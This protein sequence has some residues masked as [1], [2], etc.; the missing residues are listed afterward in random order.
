MRRTSLIFAPILGVLA[1]F[2]TGARDDPEAQVR[3]AVARWR[4]AMLNADIDAVMATISADYRGGDGSDEVQVRRFLDNAFEGGHLA[5]L[6]IDVDQAEVRVE[7]EKAWVFPVRLTLPGEERPL[8]L[9]LHLIEEYGAWRIVSFAGAGDGRGLDAVPDEAEDALPEDVTLQ[10]R[11]PEGRFVR[12]PG[13]SPR[14]QVG[15]R[16]VP[17]RSSF[18]MEIASPVESDAVLADSVS[19]VLETAGGEAVEVLRAGRQFASGYF[20]HLADHP[21][22]S[23]RSLLVFVDSTGELEPDTTYSI[24]VEAR[25]RRG[26]TLGE[27]EGVWSF[28]TEQAPDRHRLD[29]TLDL[30]AE[31]DVYW[32]GAFFNGFAKPAFATSTRQNGRVPHY[33]LMAEAR[34]AY[35][36]AWNLLRDAYLTGFEHQPNV[37]KAYPNLVREKETRRIT[38]IERRERE[39]RLH[40]EDFWGHQ[41]YGIPSG[42]PLSGDY[43]VGDEILI[44]D[45]HQSARATVIA[46]D[47]LARS[48]LVTEF[49]EPAQPWQLEYSQPPPTEENPHSPGLFP[50][51]GTYLRKFDPPG[52]ARYYWGRVHHEWDLLVKRYGFRVIPRFADAPGDLSIDGRNG[53]TAKC[54]VQLHEVTREITGHLIARYGD[55]TLDWPWVVFN[56]PDLTSVYWRTGDWEELQRFYD[57]SSDA[58]LRAFED[59]GYDSSKVQVGGLELGAI[60]GLRMRLEA[61][62]T[63]VSPTASGPGALELNAAYADPRLDGR[64]SRRVEALCEANGGRGAPFDFLS[65]HTYNYSEL[66]AAKLIRAKEVAL[67]IDPE[68]FE[69]LAI[70]NHETVPRWQPIN[71]PGAAEM[72]LG[73]GYF[74]TWAAN[75]VGRLL[76]QAAA[77]P[78]YAYGGEAPL[79]GWPAIRQNWSTLNDVVRRIEVNDRWEVIPSPIFHFVNL[80]STLGDDYYVL[81]PREI[82]GHLV[83]GFAGTTED[84]VRVLLYSHHEQD[85]QSRSDHEFEVLLELLGIEGDEVEVEQ[86]RIDRDHNSYYPLA[87][88]LRDQLA[89]AP[90]RGHTEEEFQAVADRAALKV[91][92]RSTHPVTDAGSATLTARL[93]GN[94]VNFLFVRP[95]R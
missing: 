36:H 61:F 81:P 50:P 18:Y 77:D 52:T 13:D 34:E 32:R 14:P 71:D 28:T 53:T 54:L 66:A 82:G 4:S 94:G 60:A 51:G 35:P 17:L 47:D 87:R 95:V 84:D 91:T 3:V 68:Y 30:R 11:N 56:E 41:Q 25:S 27:E 90:G 23:G 62:L 86:Y 37:F 16:H 5:G 49:D 59:H 65:I 7:Q 67:E 2:A 48:V 85:P 46:V 83:G 6:A 1:L 55:A 75:I 73:N 19:I 42:R 79:M 22:G 57:Y 26:A 63:H 31:P 15:A 33:E 89:R 44:A 74:P 29:Y 72:Y 88:E 69:T 76:Q 24:R 92:A 8:R 21:R 45:G 64:R 43:R 93:A 40:V 12:A 20:G 9:A 80:L 70:V 78:R 58:I 10:L 38:A 39:V